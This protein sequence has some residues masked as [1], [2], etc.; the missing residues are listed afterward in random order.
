VNAGKEP[1]TDVGP[2]ISREAK[3]RAERLIAEGVSKGARLVLDGRGVNVPGYEEGNFLG[4][5][6]LADVTPDMECYREEIFGPV[7]L[8][9]KVGKCF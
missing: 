6:I 7:L 5:T 9:M 8:C 1:G 2:L 3:E 4:P